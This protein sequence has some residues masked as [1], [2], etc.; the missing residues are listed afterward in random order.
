MAAA[1]VATVGENTAVDMACCTTVLGPTHERPADMLR[2]RFSCSSCFWAAL[3]PAS[4]LCEKSKS[5]G[6]TLA[7]GDDAR[8]PWADLRLQEEG[9]RLSRKESP[10][11]SF[12]SFLKLIKE[13]E[14]EE[15]AKEA[16]FSIESIRSE[17]RWWWF[18]A[19]S[20]PLISSPHPNPSTR[21]WW[22]ESTPLRPLLCC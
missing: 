15:E 20:R 21:L 4:L 10:A 17:P 6:D 5:G 12:F 8:G 9:W 2:A 13:E 18:N 16:S 1:A 22:R 3:S 7:V 14:P 11:E 19:T